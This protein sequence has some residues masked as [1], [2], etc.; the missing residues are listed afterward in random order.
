MIDINL[1]PP[2]LRNDGKGSGNSLTIN[3]PKDILLGV[4]SGLILIMV[5]VHLVLGVMWLM[6][7]SRL[8]YCNAQWGK[9]LPDKVV[10][11]A[12]YKESADI[13]KKYNMIADMTTKKALM[14]A[15]KFNT[16]SDVLPSG[17]WIRKMVLDKV[18]LTMEGSVVSKSQNEINNVGLFLSA[19]KQNNDFMKG[20]SS[21]EV[22][23]IQRAQNNAV[24][25]TDFTVMA[26][27]N[28][29]AADKSS[30]SKARNP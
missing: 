10:L 4:G 3:I 11:D 1:I 14:W 15:P 29:V 20:F 24:E 22:N 13:K 28:E 5:T 23:S 25:V 12:I 30:L 21:L 27:L 26:K 2:A 9:V 19:L 6:G 8:S 7:S 16:I 17:L 18:G